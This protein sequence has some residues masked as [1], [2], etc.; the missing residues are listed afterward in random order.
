[1]FLR[2]GSALHLLRFVVV[3]AERGMRWAGERF[4]SFSRYPWMI[5]FDATPELDSGGFSSPWNV[6]SANTSVGFPSVVLGKRVGLSCT[7]GLSFAR[8]STQVVTG[9]L[10][11]KSSRSY[12][13]SL[14]VATFFSTTSQASHSRTSPSTPQKRTGW[15]SGH[16]LSKTPVF[17]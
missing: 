8:G 10:E 3:G 9:R 2:P 16:V 11:T 1:M 7:S 17:I 6:E 4:N 15:P 5:R 14:S 13:D 12:A